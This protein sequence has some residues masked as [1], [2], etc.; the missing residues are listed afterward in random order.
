MAG[1]GGSVKLTG[2]SEYRRAIQQITQDLGKM[3]NALKTQSADFSANSNSL[4]NAEQRQNE[5]NEAI[6][7]QQAELAK[8]KTAY[9]Q[10]SVEVQAQTTRHSALTREYKAAVAELDRIG[11]E[12]GETSEEYKKQAEV[13][14]KLG[15]EL[16]DSTESMN[17]SKAAMSQLRSRINEAS[18]TIDN[19]TNEIEELG[20]ETEES[21]KKAKEAANGGFTIM[22]GVIADLTATAIK[23]ALNGLKKLGSALINIG[24][25]SYGLYAEYEQLV[26]GIETLFGDSAGKLME[27]ANNAYKTAGLSANEYMEQATSFS[28]TLLQGLGGDTEKA[29]EYANMAI[30][31]MSDNANKMGTDMSLIQNAYNGFAKQ[32]YTMLK[33][34]LAA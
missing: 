11:K 19:A 15:N 25:Q 12:S 32:N 33:G 9:A 30:S 31:D 17:E 14:D 1:F 34:Y 6:K 27:Y 8:A 5:L 18:R 7:Q 28:A 10:Y 21:G 24:K 29:V 4:K 20:D 16:A 26:G 22:K 23:A 2:E 3:S 13:V